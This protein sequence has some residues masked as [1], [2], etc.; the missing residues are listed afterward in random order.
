MSFGLLANEGIQNFEFYATKKRIGKILKQIQQTLKF[1]SNVSS[2]TY[3]AER[4]PNT[5]VAVHI[6]E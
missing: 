6:R 2:K 1:F 5:K 3:A 4:P